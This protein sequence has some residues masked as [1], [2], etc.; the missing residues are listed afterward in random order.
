MS[1][2]QNYYK[3]WFESFVLDITTGHREAVQLRL[4]K[5]QELPREIEEE[6][7][8]Q[9][10]DPY[11]LLTQCRRE[12]FNNHPVGTNFYLRAKLNDRE[13]RGLFMTSHYKFDPIDIIEPE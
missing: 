5:G 4:L 2:N 11:E 10:I 1:L 8:R 6:C 3:L 13:G 7:T 9:K 12:Y